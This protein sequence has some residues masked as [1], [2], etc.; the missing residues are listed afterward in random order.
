MSDRIK[1][2]GNKIRLMRVS[3]GLS[4]Q[5]LAKEI[6]IT[7]AHFSN[8]E[9]GRCNATIDVLLRLHDSLEVPMSAFFEEID[10]Q[11][12]IRLA[13]NN[14]SSGIDVDDLLAVLQLL[15]QAK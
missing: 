2:I 7:Q 5:S 13:K 12:G 4:Q 11:D 3:K 8:I 9:N 1:M 10:E 14:K 6:G 15:K